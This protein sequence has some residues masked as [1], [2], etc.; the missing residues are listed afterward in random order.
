MEQRDEHRLKQEFQA[1]RT[2]QVIAV[3]AAI[4]LIVLVAVLFRRPD[5]FGG[6]S[7][8]T[9]V[10]VQ[11]VVII[12]FVNFTSYN[13]RCPSCRRFLGSDIGRQTCKNCGIRLR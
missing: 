8:G 6:L 5:L 4:A 10:K 7:K 13:W 1:R 3:A 12:L 2:R 11:I 9:I